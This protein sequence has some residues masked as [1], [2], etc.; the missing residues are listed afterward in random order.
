[1][2]KAPLGPNKERLMIYRRSAAKTQDQYEAIKD[3]VNSENFD[4]TRLTPK[5]VFSDT[6]GPIRFRWFDTK[7]KKHIVNVHPNGVLENLTQKTKKKVVKKKE[8]KKK[9][10]KKKAPAKK[11]E[12]KTKAKAKKKAPAKKKKK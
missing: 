2:F 8:P 9:S 1:M 11:K 5:E 4:Y 3:I 10:A 7:G 6:P 12:K